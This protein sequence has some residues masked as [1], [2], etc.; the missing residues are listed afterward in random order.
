[1]PKPLRAGL[2]LSRIPVVTPEPPRFL[3]AYYKY[4]DEV[5]RRLMWTFPAYYYFKR[6]TLSQHRFNDLQR[7]PI[8][9]H[10]GVWYPRG[11]PDIHHNRER[12]LKQDVILPK[13]EKDQVISPQP[14]KID[15]IDK[16]PHS[17][18]R[19]LDQTLFLLIKSD[20]NEW[21][22]PSFDVQDSSESL[23][24]AAERGLR[25]LGGRNINTWT[26]SNTPAAVLRDKGTPEFLIKSHIL[27]G[28][29]APRSSEFQWLAKEEIKSTVSPEYYSKVE[30][31]L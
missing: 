10:A 14:R 28:K 25:E 8:P 22:F 7:G 11:I 17:L 24:E 18:A 13:G 26:V 19:R 5:E 15:E 30:P 16:D 31:L 20:G 29:F 21:R 2:V 6:G 12:R 9:R 4:M 3:K 27:H 1:M 23:H